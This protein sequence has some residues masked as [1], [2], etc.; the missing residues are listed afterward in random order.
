MGL[1]FITLVPRLV[2]AAGSA[3]RFRLRGSDPAQER[4]APLR[5]TGL[6]WAPPLVSTWHVSDLPVDFITRR[7][8]DA[9]LLRAVIEVLQLLRGP[10]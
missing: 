9:L 6:L 1:V 5:E 3:E 2:S 10:N 8:G 4:S 7:G